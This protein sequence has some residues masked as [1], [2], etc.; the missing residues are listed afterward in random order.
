MFLRAPP[1]IDGPAP[2]SA[3]AGAG[4]SRTAHAPGPPMAP[5]RGVMPGRKPG[6]KNRSPDRGVKLGAPASVADDA[7]P[8]ATAPPDAASG[9]RG[10][11]AAV[12]ARSTSALM[13][14]VHLMGSLLDKPVDESRDR[15]CAAP[16]P[17]ARA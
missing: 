10:A 12:A 17:W 13:A 16:I 6:S 11:H 7:A 1:Q 14:M 4:A 15:T 9:T 3:S 2:T 5:V 8:A